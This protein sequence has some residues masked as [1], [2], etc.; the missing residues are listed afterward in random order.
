MGKPD[1]RSSSWHGEY[2]ADH[3]KAILSA[4][5]GPGLFITGIDTE[6]GKTVVTASLAGA[7]R[8]L[9]MRVGIC[10]PVASGCPKH[11]DR[12]NAGVVTDD[13]YASPDAALSA[14]MAGLADNDETLMKYLSPVRFGAPVSP[15]IA[16]RIEGR[17][18]DWTRIAAAMDFWQENCDFLLVEGA[19]GWLVPLDDHDFTIADM[20]A[21]FRLPVLVVTMPTL[22]TLNVTGLTV[23]A[24]RQR[25]LVAA[26]L[27]INRVPSNQDLA[28]QTN[29]EELPRLTGAPLRATLP[30]LATPITGEVPNTFVDALYDFAEDLC[31]VARGSIDLT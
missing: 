27:V 15:H 6:V 20:A 1:R 3:P 16:S 22:G 17:A 9:G 12:G 23:Q 13:D 2:H 11:A 29:I 30:N 4:Y 18:T 25:Q 24:I 21:T 26:G 8:R 5:K 7:L 10:K 31:R 19:G 28:A 14:R